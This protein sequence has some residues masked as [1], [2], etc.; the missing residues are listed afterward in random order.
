MALVTRTEPGQG[1]APDAAD[2]YRPADLREAYGLASAAD[3]AGTGQTV[4]IVDAYADRAAASD[5]SRYR[6][7]FGLPPCGTS[8]GCL[9]IVGQAGGSALPAPDPSGGWELEESADLDMVS[10]ICPH[11]HILLVEAKSDDITDLAAAEHYAAGHA[12]SSPIAGAAAPN[13]AGRRH[14]MPI[15]V[16]LASRSS[17]RRAMTAMAPSTRRPPSS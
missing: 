17:P 8:G 15:S 3:A 2:G 13:S 16:A 1:A 5:L 6:S 10:A 9:R 7:A 11:C 12:V 4:A 14:S